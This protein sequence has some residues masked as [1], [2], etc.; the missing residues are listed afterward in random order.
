[1][2]DEIKPGYY[3]APQAGDFAAAVEPFA[4]F[5]AWFEEAKAHEPNDPNAFALATVDAAGMPNVRIV[6]LKG[7][8][9]AGDAARDRKSVV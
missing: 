7:L 8:D 4:L 3:T 2:A 6:L 9:P 5:S 1:M